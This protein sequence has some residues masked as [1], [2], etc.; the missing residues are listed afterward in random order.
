MFH[1]DQV[2]AR[3]FEY[4]HGFDR[5][6]TL[7]EHKPVY[8]HYISPEL[9]SEPPVK[10]GQNDFFTQRE[11]GKE[12]K[13][14]FFL[15]ENPKSSEPTILF[16]NNPWLGFPPRPYDLCGPDFTCNVVT[17]KAPDDLRKAD[18]VIIHPV[19]TFLE[20]HLGDAWKD[21]FSGYRSARQLYSVLETDKMAWFLVFLS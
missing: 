2:L 15:N 13:A 6:F 5:F 1:T 16:W 3:V 17:S 11:S 18:A 9:Q 7:G 21:M 14:A 8:P 10:Y 20:S 12:L 4:G 19:F